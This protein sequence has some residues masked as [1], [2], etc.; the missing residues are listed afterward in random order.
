MPVLEDEIN[1]FEKQLHNKGMQ[2]DSI[3]SSVTYEGKL[4]VIVHYGN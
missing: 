2:I 3:T 1:N 4:V